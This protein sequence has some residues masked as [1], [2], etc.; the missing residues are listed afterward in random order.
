MSAN[1]GKQIAMTEISPRHLNVEWTKAEND[2]FANLLR[3]EAFSLA[4]VVEGEDIIRL[5]RILE[6]ADPSV[7][8]AARAVRNGSLC[9]LIWEGCGSNEPLPNTP[10]R[11][12]RPMYAVSLPNRS[13]EID[14]R[15]VAL[16]AVL[17]ATSVEIQT[18]ID[19]IDDSG[20][21]PALTFHYDR[22][23]VVTI[24]AALRGAENKTNVLYPL[25]AVANELK[26]SGFVEL[27]REPCFLR[28]GRDANENQSF[29][30]LVEGEKADSTRLSPQIVEGGLELG[31]I[32]APQGSKRHGEALAAFRHEINRLNRVLLECEAPPTCAGQTVSNQNA[33]EVCLNDGSLVLMNN[34]LVMHGRRRAPALD[35]ARNR[36]L[37]VAFL[38][39]DHLR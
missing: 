38:G 30:I 15:V 18:N 10:F 24:L 11:G 5:G 1:S 19:A 9:H 22:G 28:L 36:W 26:P 39:P 23:A 20:W 4:A 21:S 17:G 31:D 25:S 37:R 6:D 32:E 13:Y 12:R 34:A 29:P 27:L 16:A 35:V 2:R 3:K 7:G 33:M 8:A 14:L